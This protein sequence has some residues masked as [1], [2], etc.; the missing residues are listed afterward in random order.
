VDIRFKGSLNGI[1]AALLIN[2]IRPVPVIFISGFI[3]SEYTD[4]AK[5]IA[6]CE[7][8]SKPYDDEILNEKIISCLLRSKNLV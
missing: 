3:N 1:K 4:E 6:V 2:K 5:K 8:I 7:F